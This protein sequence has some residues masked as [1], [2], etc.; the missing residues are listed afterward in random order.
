MSEIP[1][2]SQTLLAYPLA[3]V[4]ATM[5][6]TQPQP[7][8]VMTVAGNRNVKDLPVG[9]DG[10]EWSNGLCSKSGSW[11]TCTSPFIGV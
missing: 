8:P 10:R 6:D 2:R 3:S 1:L 9:P 11:G 7:I 5:T 4:F